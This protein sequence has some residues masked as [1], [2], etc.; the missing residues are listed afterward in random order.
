MPATRIVSLYFRCEP[1]DLRGTSS[2]TVSG[3]NGSFYPRG[4]KPSDYLP[5]YGARFPIVEVDSTFYACPTARTVEKWNARTPPGFVFSAK[6]PQTI[7]L[8]KVL[9]DC[10]TEFSE[11]METMDTLGPKLGSIIVER[12]LDETTT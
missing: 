12:C 5:F 6:V 2:F 9:V 4:M 11:F 10:D 7:T 1:A 8:D 3:W